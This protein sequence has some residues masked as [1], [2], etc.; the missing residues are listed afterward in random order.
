MGACAAGELYDLLEAGPLLSRRG[1]QQQNE[2][3]LGYSP[4]G[5]TPVQ[6]FHDIALQGRCSALIALTPDF[7][8]IFLGHSTWDSYSQ[9]TKVFKH[10]GFQ[11]AGIPN[12]AAQRMSF[13][14]YPGELFSDDDL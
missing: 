12:L 7:S 2:T 10:Y 14:S 9:M 13:S 3:H 6:I 5:R 1:Q 4:K 11:L 8:D